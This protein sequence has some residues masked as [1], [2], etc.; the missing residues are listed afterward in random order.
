MI[1][2]SEKSILNLTSDIC[3]HMMKA[4]ESLKSIKK[5]T[6]QNVFEFENKGRLIIMYNPTDDNMNDLYS[7]EHLV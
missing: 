3:K 7:Q 1:Y 2:L 4:H 5:I 6:I